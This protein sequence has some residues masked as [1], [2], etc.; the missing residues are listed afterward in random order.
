MSKKEYKYYILFSKKEIINY[1]IVL[2][3]LF[4]KDNIK[5]IIS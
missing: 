3:N 4:N 1:S 2:N 5:N